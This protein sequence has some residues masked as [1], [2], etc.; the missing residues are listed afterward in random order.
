[1]VAC[2]AVVV[3]CGALVP[4]FISIPMSIDSSSPCGMAVASDARKRVKVAATATRV[5]KGIGKKMCY[6]ARK[7]YCVC[8]EM[9]VRKYRAP[10]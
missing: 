3:G 2:V 6:S 1:V 5:A 8:A 9:Q 7:W 10:T 4:M